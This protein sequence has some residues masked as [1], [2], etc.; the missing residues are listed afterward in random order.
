[1]FLYTT[2]TLKKITRQWFLF[3]DLVFGSDSAELW[4]LGGAG[5]ARFS[6]GFEPAALADDSLRRRPPPAGGVHTIPLM[7]TP[8]S[9]SSRDTDSVSDAEWGDT[10]RLDCGTTDLDSWLLLFSIGMIFSCIADAADRCRVPSVVTDW[11]EAS[12]T[13][14]GLAGARRCDISWAAAGTFT[15]RLR[16]IQVQDV[17]LTQRT[18]VQGG[19]ASDKIDKSNL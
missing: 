18:K 16:Q 7:M 4:S 8:F 3:L 1:M 17:K 13:D 14:A 11:N 9:I 12:T 15:Q 2:Y 5:A 19:E 10:C 6:K